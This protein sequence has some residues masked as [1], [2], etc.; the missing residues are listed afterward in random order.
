MSSE[1]KPQRGNLLGFVPELS[2]YYLL[3]ALYFFAFGMQFVLFPSLVAFFLDATPEGVG[4]AQSALSAP[5]FCLLLFGGLLAERSQAGPT[6]AKLHLIFAFASIALAGV[7]A[8]GYLTY[9]T[10][11]AYAML[12][13]ACA[14]FMMPVRDAALNGVVLRETA[15]GRY[16]P[17]ATAAA[18]TTAVQIGAQIAGILVA[19]LAGA[20]PAPYLALQAIVL[21]F[22]AAISLG[23]Q[24]PKPTGHERTLKGAIRDLR[25]GIAY[26][27]RNPIMSP[28]LISAL[29]VG[30]FVV[31]SFQVLFPLIVRDHYGGTDQAQQGQLGALFAVFWGASFVSAVILSRLK[32]LKHP[33]RALIV[34]HLVSAV[35]LFTFAFDKS[36]PAFIA[37]VSLWGLAAGVAISMSRTITQGAAEP[38]YLGRVLAVY[39]MGFMGGAP[40]GSAIMGFAASE[41]D[42]RT[43]ALIPAGGLALAALALALT[44]P[45][46]R[47]AQDHAPEVALGD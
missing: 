32:P 19:R 39:S 10:L 36:F 2:L 25:E 31:G 14:A 3:V 46:W 15:R 38:R 26:S 47:Y 29:Y 24:D 23:L 34:S 40:I 12:V 4:L 37:V 41:L 21:S 13:G 18:A 22:G 33:G 44:T 28:M 16:T 1:Q 11:I 27:F 17:I 42:P 7:V 30:V 9:E 35:M 43:A 5:L 6:L 20:T 45:I 8:A